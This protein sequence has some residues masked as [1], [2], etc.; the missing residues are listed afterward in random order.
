MS[1]TVTMVTFANAAN[2]AVR[3]SVED[4]V[5]QIQDAKVGAE[6]FVR[7]IAAAN[8]RPL[9]ISKAML[10]AVFGVF[11]ADTSPQNNIAV[12]QG[13]QAAPFRRG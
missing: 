11:E 2:F 12:V 8:G 9:F 13:E 10:D 4:I 7:F 6:D 3:G 5:K 1:K